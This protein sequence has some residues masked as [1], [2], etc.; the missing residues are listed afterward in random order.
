MG[1]A[2]MRHHLAARGVA[3]RVH[4]AGT[5]RWRGAATPEAVEAMRE[6]GLDVSTHESRNLTP[7]LIESSDLVLGMTR[8]HID[9]V[10]LHCP[11]AIERTFMVR[12]LARLGALT[13]PRGA[14]ETVRHWLR[15]VAALREPGRP[16]GH[17]QDEI[18]DPVGEPLETYR[19]T[20]DRLDEALDTIAGLLAGAPE[21]V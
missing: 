13:G 6:R 19:A 5:M 20:A 21:T 18:D 10:A 17:P 7:A 14:S 1:E 16:V 11:D 15:R 2:L 4:S 8:A 3:A 12:E 9:F